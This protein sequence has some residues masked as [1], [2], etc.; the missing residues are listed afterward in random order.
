MLTSTDAMLITPL[1]VL[2]CN[3]TATIEMILTLKAAQ[4]D[5]ALARN[6][7]DKTPLM[8][9][10]ESKRKKFTTFHEDGE[11][12]SLLGLLEQGLDIDALE[13]IQA[14]NGDEMVFVSELQI[15]HEA[16]GLL[17]FMYA[18]SLPQC[19]LDLVYVLAMK[20]ADLLLGE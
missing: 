12:L 2:C 10:L 1:H 15:A 13:V 9:L 17:P 18:A 11:L 3:P 5:M 8:M 4:P 7:M 14:Y 20:R 6:V 19:R 16:S